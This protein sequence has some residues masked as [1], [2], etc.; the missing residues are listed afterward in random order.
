MS[1]LTRYRKAVD[2]YMENYKEMSPGEREDYEGTMRRM[3]HELRRSG[4]EF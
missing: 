3:E 4:V 2:F 1:Q